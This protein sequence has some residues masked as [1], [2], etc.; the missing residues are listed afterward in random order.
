M[1]IFATEKKKPEILG[2]CNI[3]RKMA[4]HVRFSQF[5]KIIRRDLY[6]SYQNHFKQS[7]SQS[8]C[9]FVIY[10][11][12]FLTTTDFFTPFDPL[13]GTGRASDISLDPLNTLWS[14]QQ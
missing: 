12:V 2:V 9:M 14:Q 6:L 5:I 7:F 8:F 13:R 11:Y 1:L 10:I 3:S 4:L